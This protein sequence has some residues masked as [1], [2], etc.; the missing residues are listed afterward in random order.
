MRFSLQ[1]QKTTGSAKRH[2]LWPIPLL[3]W[4]FLLVLTTPI[5]YGTVR[6]DMLIHVYFAKHG[7]AVS[8]QSH[9]V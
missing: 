8:Y 4:Q 7:S 5:A 6:P 9:V 1:L 2:Y 3:F